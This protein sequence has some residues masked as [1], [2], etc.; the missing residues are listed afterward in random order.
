MPAWPSAADGPAPGQA[1]D[2]FSSGH[3]LP[4]QHF[5]PKYHAKLAA[6]RER[7]VGRLL[8]LTDFDET[9]TSTR[10]RDGAHGD[11]CHEVLLRYLDLD[12][13]AGLRERLTP[14]IEWDSL[15]EPQ[16]MALCGGDESVRAAKTRWWFAAFQQVALDFGLADRVAECI[17]KSNAQPR[18]GLGAVFRWLEAR[19]VPLL[20]VSAGVQ[21]VLEAILEAG[22]A[23]LPSTA[24]VVAND[25]RQ[26]AVR[27][28]SRS[29]ATAL[30]LVPGFPGVVAGRDAVLLLGDK[31]SDCAVAGGLPAGCEVLKVGFLR[32]VDTTPEKVQCFLTYFDVALLGDPPMDFVAQLLSTIADPTRVESH[33]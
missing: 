8:V 20:I 9:L 6:L 24:T 31:P 18:E 32:P 12:Q 23:P 4:R 19:G 5:G 22:H 10:G 17:V 27:V 2:T 11:Q 1:V 28:T 7:G 26:L 30:E 29:K 13:P 16:K 25:L 14:L 33:L 21:Q 15:P 3:D